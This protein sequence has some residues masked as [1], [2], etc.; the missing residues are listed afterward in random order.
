MARM[1][2]AFD[3][4]ER[5]SPPAWKQRSSIEDDLCRRKQRV[6]GPEQ[7]L[8]CEKPYPVDDDLADIVPHGEEPRREG[9]RELGAHLAGILNN[10]ALHD[11]HVLELHGRD[12]A[13]PRA[14]EQGEGDQGP[15][16]QLHIGGVRHALQDMLDLLERGHRPFR[17]RLCDPGF[18]FRER[19]VVGIRIG[20][21]GSIARLAGQPLKESCEAR[22]GC[23]T[24]SAC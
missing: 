10:L 9:L 3:Q 16:A 15:V 2:D 19:E 12:R 17:R 1:G 24:A 18:L 22:S 7:L 11:V 20:Q 13:V 14:G 23:Q 6:R 21:A 4:W 5:D 8:T